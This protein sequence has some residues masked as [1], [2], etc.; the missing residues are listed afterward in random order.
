[1][2]EL[3]DLEP[4]GDGNVDVVAFMAVDVALEKIGM[5]VGPVTR[6]T[7]RFGWFSATKEIFC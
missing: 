1:M 2:L 4:V 7:G 6:F 5:Y 3:A